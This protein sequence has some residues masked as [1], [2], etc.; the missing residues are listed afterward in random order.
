[1]DPKTLPGPERKKYLE[2]CVECLRRAERRIC[3]SKKMLY[4]VSRNTAAYTIA[5]Q[6]LRIKRSEF[7]AELMGLPWEAKPFKPPY[8]QRPPR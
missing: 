6:A 2:A 4:R 3:K 1:M 7:V 5:V 8:P